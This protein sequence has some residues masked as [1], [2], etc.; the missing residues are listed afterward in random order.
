[1]FLNYPWPGNVRQLQNVIRNVVVLNT[2]DTVTAGMVP[3]P[4]NPNGIGQ[5]GAP[6]FGSAA[7]TAAPAMPT[8]NGAMLPLASGSSPAV[9]APMAEHRGRSPT[10][11]RRRH[12]PEFLSPLE[13]IIN[14]TAAGEGAP[15]RKRADNIL[16]LWETEKLAIEDAITSCGGNIPKAAALLGISASTI[17]RKRQH[18]ESLEA[19]AEA[20]TAD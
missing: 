18:W 14:P 20:T 4:V 10:R 5:A 3:A 11:Q 7:T 2:G 19:E 15:V 16:P 13:G 8:P 9:S 12:V 1:M 17:Y 6:G